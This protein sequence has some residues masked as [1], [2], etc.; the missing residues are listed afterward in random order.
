MPDLEIYWNKVVTDFRRV[1]LLKRQG[2][3]DASENILNGELTE[4]IA[5]WSQQIKQEST[6]K[7]LTLQEMFITEE[8]RVEEAWQIQQI[9][10]EEIRARL[11]TEVQNQ[12]RDE[13]R[14]QVLSSLRDQVDQVRDRVVG[15]VRNQ[16]DEAVRSAL[17]SQV[18]E[19]RAQ[20]QQANP[21]QA[22]SWL[23]SLPRVQVPQECMSFA[24]PHG[25][26]S[27]DVR[28]ETESFHEF[29]PEL[30]SPV[31][32]PLTVE[33]LRSMRGPRADDLSAVLDFILTDQAEHDLRDMELAAA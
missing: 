21:P 17:A 25:L 22:P 2:K 23:D 24:L 16:V 3:P 27:E 32:E 26:P 19:P 14:S 33:A 4:S 13:V 10:L 29:K 9:V 8:H 5:A 30:K 20:V 7:R 18:V 6:A 11:T 15:E 31:S 12:V 28:S 1:C